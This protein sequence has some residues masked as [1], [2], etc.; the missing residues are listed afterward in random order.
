[1]ARRQKKIGNLP[2]LEP[3]AAGVDVGA[4][5]IFVAVPPDRDAEPVRCFET[6][7]SDLESLAAWLQ[8]CGI[9]TVAMESTGVYWI[10]LFQILERHEIEAL[11]VNARHVKNV[12]GRKSDPGFVMNS[13]RPGRTREPVL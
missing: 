5:Q 2:I 1:M 8:K 11:L 6:F 3:N 4:T 7:T 13:C 10:P 9:R 12:P